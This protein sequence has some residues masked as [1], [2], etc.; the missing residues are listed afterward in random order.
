M[1]KGILIVLAVVIVGAG[2][3]YFVSPLF[4]HTEVNEAFPDI[5]ETTTDIQEQKDSTTDTPNTDQ[6]SAATDSG[7][8]EPTLLRM[9]SFVDAD[10][11][12]KG[13]GEASV[14]M[15]PSGERILRFEDFEVTN[16]PGLHVFLSAHPN[17]ASSDQTK[18]DGYL[19]LGEL[20]GSKGSQNY[21]LS[22]DIDLSLYQSVVIYCYPFN[23]VFS[24]ATL[25]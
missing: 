5:T 20:K 23:V 4:I 6:G 3:W 1:K 17:P 9:G 2:L 8:G 10:A 7:L 15:L 16:G 25:K 11:I 22:P 13:S 24:T 14:Y 18:D 21:T 19:D 12:H